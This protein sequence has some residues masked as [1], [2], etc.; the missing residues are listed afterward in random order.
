MGERNPTASIRHLTDTHHA[1][2]AMNLTAIYFLLATVFTAWIY[3]PLSNAN[4]FTAQPS[5]V[6]LLTAHPDDECM[7][8]SPT[9]LALTRTGSTLFSLCLSAGDQDGLGATRAEELEGSLNVLGIPQTHRQLV[10]HKCVVRLLRC[11][12]LILV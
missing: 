12:A 10:N 6:L 11:R 7:F 9:L 4:V 8:F 3:Y 2:H 5:N 1:E